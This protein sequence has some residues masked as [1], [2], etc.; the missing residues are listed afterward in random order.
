MGRGVLSPADYWVWA[1]CRREL[2]QWGPGKSPDRKHIL[3]A[4]ERFLYLYA[5]ALSKLVLEI[6]KHDKI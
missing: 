3:A 1:D 5:D 2:P 6:L 4:T